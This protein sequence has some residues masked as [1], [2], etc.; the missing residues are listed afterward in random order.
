MI[1]KNNI[2]MES[3][4]GKLNTGKLYFAVY[5]ESHTLI[6]KVSAD[7]KKRMTKNAGL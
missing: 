1:P 6:K 4:Y 2:Q 3:I 5:E 7:A